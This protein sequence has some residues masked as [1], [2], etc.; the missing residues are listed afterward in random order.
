MKNKAFIVLIIAAI[1]LG[2]ALTAS[3]VIRVYFQPDNP[4]NNV[5]VTDAEETKQ[6]ETLA[7]QETSNNEMVFG[8][9]DIETDN[10]DE[11]KEDVYQRPEK[12]PVQDISVEEAERYEREAKSYFR[13]YRFLEGANYLQPIVEKTP[14]D[15]NAKKLHELFFAASLLA[16]LPAPEDSSAEH[17][18]LEGI[19]NIIS[20]VRDPELLFFAVMRLDP[21]NRAEVILNKDSLNPVL[22]DDTIPL[23]LKIDEEEE[24]LAEIRPLYQDVQLMHRVLFEVE[25]NQL[26]AYIMEYPDGELVFYSIRNLPGKTTPYKT[27]SE[28]ERIL[29]AIRQ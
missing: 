9:E 19:K 1:V 6:T 22:E 5:S 13:E 11:S 23:V 15:G 26:Y 10:Q 4:E 28:W 16:N 3:V 29:E 21:L 25:G 7:K 18:D 27:I 24:L 2:I 8:D 17:L 14:S 20:H 12:Q